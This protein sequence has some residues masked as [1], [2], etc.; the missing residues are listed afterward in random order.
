LYFVTK[1]RSVFV[2]FITR[3]STDSCCDDAVVVCRTWTV[4]KLEWG[5]D[6]REEASLWALETRFQGLRI[7]IRLDM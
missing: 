4:N 6:G 2:R 7:S 1:R 5:Q 3:F